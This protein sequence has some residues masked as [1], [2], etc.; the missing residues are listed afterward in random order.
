MAKLCV[1]EKKETIMLLFIDLTPRNLDHWYVLACS[2]AHSSTLNRIGL[3][4]K[5]SNERRDLCQYPQKI[6]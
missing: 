4:G 1:F 3:V 6:G 2:F 5:K